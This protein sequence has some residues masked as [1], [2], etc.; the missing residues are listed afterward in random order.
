M[1]YNLL[2]KSNEQIGKLSAG[3]MIDLRDYRNMI[4]QGLPHRV[5]WDQVKYYIITTAG[6]TLWQL[7]EDFLNSDFRPIGCLEPPVS[8]VEWVLQEQ[9]ILELKKKSEVILVK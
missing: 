5:K 6:K 9:Y 1:D 4:R 2:L 7:S 3:V 8:L